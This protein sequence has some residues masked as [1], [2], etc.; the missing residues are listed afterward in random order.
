VSKRLLRYFLIG[1]VLLLL[2]G[3]WAFSF[4]LF[5][6]FE[7]GYEYEVASLIPREVDFYVAK[8]NLSNDFDPFPRPAFLDEFEGSPSGQA[9]SDLGLA[10]LVERWRIRDTLA[11]LDRALARLPIEV[12]PLGLFGG[13][14]LALAGNFTGPQL[15][16]ADWAVYGRTGWLGKLGVEL[17]SGGWVD[18]SPQGIQVTELEHEGEA[19]GVSLAGGTLPRAV[20]LLRIRDVVIVATNPQFLRAAR[21][22]EA[23]RG[24]DSF[25]LSAKYAD[26]LARPER[27]GDELELY[28]DQRSLAENLKLPGTWPD[29]RANVLGTALLAKLFQIGVV[30]ELIGTLD[31]DRTLTLELV[32]ELSSNALTPFQQRLYDQRGFDKQQ[33]LEVAQLVPADAG[34]LAYLHGDAGDLLRELRS[35]VQ[36]IDPAAISNLEDLVRLVW[37]HNDLDPL[38]DELDGAFRDRVAFFVRDYDWPDEGE[39]GPPHDD[40]PVLAWALVLW[41]QDAVKVEQLAAA[42]RD[43]QD[44]F[45]IRG[46]EPGSNGLFENTLAGGAKVYEYW[47]PLV[48]G[49]GH[50]ARLEMKGRDPYLVLSNENRLLGQIFKTYYQEA[51]AGASAYPRLSESPAFLTWANGGLPSANLLVWLDPT[52][53]SATLRRIAAHRTELGVGD[54][55]DWSVERPRI[56]REVL[57][58]NFPGE[59]WGQVSAEKQDSFQLLVDEEVQ[60]FELAFKER[61]A[62]ELHG[63][64]ERGLTALAA[65]RGAFFE[66]V[67]DRKRL[68]LHGRVALSFEP[69]GGPE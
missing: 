65:L 61:R 55:I 30:R 11:E 10:H 43:N 6:P 69:A 41:P 39:A 56:E 4:F 9:L 57:A 7:G 12:D 49:T 32:G 15:A 59:T 66:L 26:N 35:V 46:R 17:V 31:F 13:K 42:I 3:L 48:P 37:N 54:L 45:G 18:L 51:G 28:L 20:H 1:L 22:F 25:G 33:M 5:N 29:P 8:K 47:N 68:A 21:A 27:T 52:A 14:A 19:L 16:Q 24:Q 53:V 62:P 36:A 40:T 63:R 64:S 2:G 23:N 67:T 58:R 38:I 34:L 50:V 60:R 44:K